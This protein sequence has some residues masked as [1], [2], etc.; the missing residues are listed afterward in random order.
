MNDLAVL[1]GQTPVLDR[2][3][4]Q[5]FLVIDPLLLLTAVVLLNRPISVY[6]NV[7]NLFGVF[8]FQLKPLLFRVARSQVVIFVGLPFLDLLLENTLLRVSERVLLVVDSERVDVEVREVQDFGLLVPIQQ[9]RVF[10]LA[11]VIS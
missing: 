2:L 9:S 10:H 7:K 1:L 11:D 8:R 6:I 5:H 3:V 4:R